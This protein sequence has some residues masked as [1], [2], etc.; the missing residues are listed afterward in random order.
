M[1]SFM[2]S[3]QWRGPAYQKAAARVLAYLTKVRRIGIVARLSVSFVAVAILAIAANYLAGHSYVTTQTVRVERPTLSV[4]RPVAAAPVVVAPPAPLPPPKPSEAALEYSRALQRFSAAVSARAAAADA[5]ADAGF[6]NAG[7]RLAQV[8]SR[9]STEV[10]KSDK[11]L[12]S[13]VT[14]RTKETTDSAQSLIEEADERRHLIGE[15]RRHLDQLAQGMKTALDGSFKIFGRLIAREYLLKLDMN[16]QGIRGRMED[17]I[18]SNATAAS[19][20]ALAASER[21]FSVALDANRSSLQ[22]VQGLDWVNATDNQLSVLVAFRESL[23]HAQSAYSETQTKLTQQMA[24]AAVVAAECVI[25]VASLSP[26]SSLRT[27]A[28][29]QPAAPQPSVPPA[30]ETPA[31]VADMPAASASTDTSPIEVP[32]PQTT[33]LAENDHGRNA[34]MTR[35]TIAVISSVFIISLLTVLSVVRPVRRLVNAAARLAAGDTRIAVVRGGIKELDQLAGS[36]NEMARQ[37]ESAGQ[38]SRSY[39]ARLEADVAARTEEL[40]QLAERDSLTQL[41]NRR[42]GL[43]LMERAFETTRTRGGYVGVFFLDLDNFK[44]INDSLGHAFGDKVLLG[45]AERLGTLCT[46]YG[47]ATRLGGDEFCIVHASAQ[48]REEIYEAAT[49][50]VQAF[51]SPLALE[52]RELMVSVSCGVSVFPLHGDTCAELLS[53]ADA[54]LYRAKSSGRN[55]ASIYTA[56]LLEVVSERFSLEQRLRHAVS[57]GEFELVFQPEVGSHSL[58]V[59][60]VEAL[61]RWRQPD[62]RLAAPGEFLAVAETSGF[63]TEIDNWVMNA[64]V[65]AAATWHHG[66][67][68]QA[69]VAINVS[70]RQLLDISFVD[71]LKELMALHKLP[72]QCIEIELTETVLQT[73]AD[74][75]RTL[76]ALKAE[77]FAIGLD[78]FG[79]GY[80][81]LTSLAQLPLSRVKLDR[82]LVIGNDERSVAI[83]LATVT[84]CEH[85]ELEVTA[86]GIETAEQLAWL[87]DHDSVYLQGYLISRPL[88]FEDIEAA[89]KRIPQE[90]ALHVLNSRASQP[91]KRVS[92]EV[93]PFMSSSIGM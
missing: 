42:H 83:A 43:E 93:I 60:L 87:L 20:S 62:G 67:W 16:L 53:S 27:T 32:E 55:Q 88:R 18:A 85:L 49:Q 61:L 52:Q 24:D 29:K 3:R 82:S 70:S 80:S 76:H 51:H 41:P 31:T 84:L 63:M 68:P 45:V 72:A 10:A 21:E 78:D 6:H 56:D 69:R 22:K 19:L 77:G 71:R 44:S 86:E 38:A 75:I 34:L 81:S 90:M 2:P 5:E 59:E 64:A 35:I 40:R 26:S 13:Q 30:A 89:L 58:H 47:Y 50:L 54:A 73:G 25:P 36:F 48:T 14:S 1:N 12:S 57:R 66:I 39:Q 8:A 17:T 23:Q 91:P 92:G 37:L 33:T 9:L 28:S 65:E 46:S 79:T 74:T 7:S 11:K 4:P 15:Y